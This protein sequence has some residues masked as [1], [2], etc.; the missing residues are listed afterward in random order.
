[1][2]IVARLNS[3]ARLASQRTD[4]IIVAFMLMAIAMMIIPLPT[5]L[6][7]GLIGINI[8]L[9]LLILIVAFYITHSVDFS[10]LPPLI[11]LSTLFR[12]ALSITTTRLILL[13]GDA[14]HIVQ[15]F[16]DFVI[17]GQVM[18]GLVVFLII[19]IAQF[20]VITKGAERVAEVAARFTLDAMPGKQ[21]S[22][23]NDLR[24]GDID[25]PQARLRRSRV[26]RESQMFGAMDG[27]MKFVK[28][29]AIASLI[30]LAVNL[31]GGLVIGMVERDMAFADAARTYALLSVGD[32][33]ISQIPALMIS[34]AAGTVVTRVNSDGVQGD[35]GSEIVRQLG[36][37]HRALALTALVLAGI[38]LLPGFPA[39]VFF[40]L[41]LLFAAG[42]L[43]MRR[44]Q[45]V[46]VEDDAQGSE[47]SE[48]DSAVAIPEP[49]E[50]E[51]KPLD[52][53]LLLVLGSALAASTPPHGLRQRMESLSY[54]I[55]AELGI[56]VPT[57]EI[58]VDR[59]AAVDQFRIELEGVPVN[60][61]SLPVG[62]LLLQDDPVHLQLAQV[63]WLEG[64]SPLDRL[65]AHW[66][67]HRHE[68]A[69]KAA[70]VDFLYPDEVLR[71]MLE[72]TLR[73][74]AGDFIGIQETRSFLERAESRYDEL[75]KEVL[76]NVPLQR[77]A[78]TL[79]LLIS[80]G[81]SIRNQRALLEAMVEWGARETNASILA[82]HL[83]MSLARQ[84]SHQH[85]D[86]H[87][88]ISA[89]ILAPQLEE[90]LL[91][92]LR[93]KNP[94]RD[95]FTE[96]LSRPLMQQLRN[97][98]EPL[99]RGCTATLLVHPELRRGLL[100]LSNRGDLNMAVLSFRELATEYYVQAL[101][102]IDLTAISNRPEPV[103]APVPSLANAS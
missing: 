41:A 87:R 49:G 64:A 23:D 82:E 88:V 27:A 65:P 89:F 81:V 11:L 66:V 54:E 46:V 50:A 71:S 25:Q 10:A 13:H 86:R 12:L 103:A 80:E 70:G 36:A 31:L 20:I 67:E 96:D 56:D 38:G 29:D 53:R 98:C 8:A 5:F 92:S 40:V 39:A 42:A 44:Q 24:N 51:I 28:G 55:R 19:T 100:R 22:I 74:Y 95:V 75:V 48:G 57:P 26:E 101:G 9:S 2:S 77:M 85:A 60:E 76:R 102:T 4:V 7:D 90:Q 43:V 17:G 73:R 93:N 1:M 97:T 6:V 3:L 79:R 14:G 61:G 62:Q 94:G 78:E 21:M 47:S 15:A 30:I 37:N 69:L 63:P 34:V 33:L 72:Q 84:L 35:L 68:Q 59:S 32:G 18:V 83:R 91:S 16:G 52:S 99:V 45:N 58:Y